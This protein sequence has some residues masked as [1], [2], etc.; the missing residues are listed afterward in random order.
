MKLARVALLFAAL[1]VPVASC[2]AVVAAL[3]TVSAVVIDA[4][5]VVDTI[6][7]FVD[8]VF[9]VKPDPELQAKIGKAIART[10]IALD[11]ALRIAQGTDKLTKEQLD[12]AF[13][14]F[15]VAYADLI[16]LVGPLGVTTGE[17]LHAR[18]GGL[19]V[20]TPLALKL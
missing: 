9:K 12:G 2:A 3:P 15:R 19:T 6:A 5:L 11:A 17:G 13:A 20:P 10:K 7:Q 4:M 1:S 18:P 14:D 8:G 16:A